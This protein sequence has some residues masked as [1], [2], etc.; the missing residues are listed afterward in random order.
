MGW[1]R[2]A[3]HERRNRAETAVRRYRYLPA[4]S[5][6]PPSVNTRLDGMLAKTTQ[7]AAP[8]MVG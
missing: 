5:T 1:R 6:F 4:L 3:R 7:S 8:L 2:V